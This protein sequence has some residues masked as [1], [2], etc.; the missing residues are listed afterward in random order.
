[1]TN[2]ATLGNTESR[3]WGQCHPCDSRQRV[4]N[5]R[6]SRLRENRIFSS[7]SKFEKMEFDT[8]P[9]VIELEALAT[10]HDKISVM[11]KPP[12]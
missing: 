2:K 6:S 9:I 11:E 5:Q 7:L 1:M 3:E 4:A 8:G 10:L 12:V